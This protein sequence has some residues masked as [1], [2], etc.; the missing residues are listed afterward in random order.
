[1][2]RLPLPLTAIRH[3]LPLAEREEVIRDLAAELDLR[4][5]RDGSWT[6]RRWLW[7]QVAGSAPALL[8]R[9]WWRAWGGFEPSANRMQPG[10]P[11]MEGWIM[12]ARYSARR[13]V[14]RPLY[15]TLAILT[16]ALGIGGM[17]TIFAI[18]R[19]VLLE[20]LPVEDEATLGIFWMQGSW[21]GEE[22]TYIRGQVPGFSAVAAWRPDDA[23]LELRDTPT[24]LLAG[25]AASADLFD[26]LGARPAIGRTFQRGEDAIGA[27]R[28]AVLSDG[29]WRELGADPGILGRRLELDGIERTIIGVMPRGFWFPDPS[30]R[31][32]LPD[33]I[34]PSGGAGIYGLVGRA[35]PGQRLDA[36]QPQLARL[37][38][39]LGGRF[40][41]SPQW[42]KTRAPSV[43]PIRESFVGPLRP[44]LVATV[45]AMAVIL[46]I[47]CANVAALMLGQVE[48]RTT[49]LAVRT[50][51]GA[52]RARL[53]RQLLL[54]AL[55]LGDWR[56]FAAALGIAI[57]SAVAIAAAPAFSLR[58]DALRD[59]LG[60][61][62]TGGIGGRGP[63]ESALVVAE[64][65]LAVLMAAGAGLLIR[66]VT[67]L[68]AVDPGVALHGTGVIDV[69]L[70]A[71]ARTV[72]RRQLVREMVA[73]LRTVP[74]VET[75]GATQKLPLRSM[76]WVTGISIDGRADASSPT[77][78]I[79]M[80]TPDYL[81]AAGIAL[82]R[83]RRFSEADA[84]PT[85]G[86]PAGAPP[87]T[88][89]PIA[90][91][92][93]ND[94]FAKRFFPG[95]DP[96][97]RQFTGGFGERVEVV[98][99]VE[100]VAEA[101]LTGERLPARYVLTERLPFLPEP[102]ALVFRA[103][104][105]VDPATL[106]DAGRRAIE[107]AAPAVAVQEA[108]TMARVF[109]TA[110]GPVR[111][112]VT[113][114]SILTGLALLLGAIG[115]Y[116]VISHF[117]ARRRRDWGVRIAL[118]LAP[119]RVVATIVGRGSRLVALGVVFGIAA[120]AALSR[121]L[122]T[123]LYGVGRTDLLAL[124]GATAVLFV[125]GLI[126]AFVPAL[127]ASRVDPAIVLREQ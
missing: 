57:L 123:F 36:M 124:G 50:A 41:Y 59:A 78:I 90:P 38:R 68:Y 15:A 72:Q 105:G 61:T 44:A 19:G 116:G 30:I 88:P 62:R 51:L 8:R 13:L 11:S 26:V 108:S 22:F 17:T 37:A 127:R 10:G 69:S 40:K 100:D 94:A 121:L 34:D 79:R 7:R 70:P 3:L 82:R 25:V 86:A 101:T 20:P 18:V 53:T 118:G 58:R 54:E 32:W 92:V 56:V 120:F 6:A 106:L 5:R 55:L 29:L 83:G 93:I 107:R 63:L 49:E 66:S 33:P 99:I 111:Q 71:N 39:M 84:Q 64:V 67:K 31:V 117:V 125:V 91:A 98:G 80:V 47:A 103:R 43:T 114:V 119:S 2:A 14:R 45:A 16:L 46:L 96:I 27:E 24:R 9:S 87:G 122:A 73:A 81:D 89:A 52:N 126:A 4:M 97:G 21:R 113:L 110:V 77:A 102:F 112:L 12:D 48:G 35:A 104:P 60:R 95:V 65:A 28:V 115:I 76:G 1:M 75:V 42:D 85:A 109:A 74:G 23:T